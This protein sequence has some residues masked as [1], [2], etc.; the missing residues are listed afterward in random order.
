MMEVNMKAFLKTLCV[1]GLANSLIACATSSDYG[2][3][4][5]SN[6]ANTDSTAV[7]DVLTNSKGFSLYTFAKDTNSKSN[8]NGGCAAK[9]PPYLVGAYEKNKNMNVI[10]RDDGSKQWA[11]DGQPLYLWINDKNPG[12]ITGHGIKNV[13]FAARAD[14]VPVSTYNQGSN[15]IL[16]T[17]AQHSLYTFD[18]D[19][20]G[21]SNCNGQCAAVWPPLVAQ[22]DDKSS[23]PFNKIERSDG[24]FQ[25][26]LNGQP[27]YTWVGDQKPGDITGDGVKG[28]WHLAKQ[29]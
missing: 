29:P 24:S 9:W 14:D 12:D 23:A 18:K 11:I 5:N 6:S 2:Y 7:G 15:K 10:V 21:K 13:W 22:E 26:T 19:A 17:L 27:L 1:I 28:V 3:N 20:Q 4:N 8:C 16:T 25:W